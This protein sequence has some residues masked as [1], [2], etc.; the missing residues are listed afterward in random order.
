MHGSSR[1]HRSKAIA[2][3]GAA[4]LLVVAMATTTAVAAGPPNGTGEPHLL[5]AKLVGNTFSARLSCDRD[6][7][8]VVRTDAH[9]ARL[10][11]AAYTCRT[12][13]A[14]ARA[15]LT[16][17][18]AR[19][20][21]SA[22]RISARPAR[23]AQHV[24][25]VLDVAKPERHPTRG[26]AQASSTGWYGASVSAYVNHPVYANGLYVSPGEETFGQPF[27][28]RVWWQS[29]VETYNPANGVYKWQYRETWTA[30]RAGTDSGRPLDYWNPLKNIWYRAAIWIYPSYEWH[31]VP[32]SPIVFSAG[33]G[34]RVESAP[35]GWVVFR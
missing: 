23:G 20:T 3:V 27:D 6:G 2:A 8:L 33:G 17:G 21:G 22:L 10:G 18:A 29:L 26:L 14:T 25:G 31:Y 9:T 34:V 32:L 24:I 16:T 35:G 12:G 1:D 4:A 11:S 28:S 15:H 13:H 5:K 30:Q 19:L 7:V